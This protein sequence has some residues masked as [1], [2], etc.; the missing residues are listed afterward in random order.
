MSELAVKGII[1]YPKDMISGISKVGSK[2]IY[3]NIKE[4]RKDAISMVDN[5][6]STVKSL[7]KG[8]L[9][10]AVNKG[11]G[12]IHNVAAMFVDSAE[13]LVGSVIAVGTAI[14]ALAFAAVDAAGE[15]VATKLENKNN[16]YAKTAGTALRVV[17]GRNQ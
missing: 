9:D 6:K 3:K 12:A 17:F 7:V 15:G 8:E 4:T 14:P 1:D 2:M 11:C 5:F 10:K 16:N 13:F